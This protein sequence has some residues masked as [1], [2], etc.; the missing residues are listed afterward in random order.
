MTRIHYSILGIVLLL[1]LGNSGLSQAGTNEQSLKIDSAG[2]LI[3]AL[4]TLN[5]DHEGPYTAQ[6]IHLSGDIEITR[7]FILTAR[8]V[9]VPTVC[10]KRDDCRKAV[11]MIIP[12]NMTGVKCIKTE[13]VLG[14]EH[15]IQAD[16]SEKSTFRL[17]A[18]LIDTHPWTYN[19]I[20]VIEFV[21]ASADGCK[22]GE[23]Q[24]ARDKT[25]WKDFNSYCRYCLERPVETCACQ[26]EKGSLPD[27]TACNF[28]ISGDLICSGKCRDGQCAAIDER[29]R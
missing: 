26:N 10:S 13:E 19:F 12:K 14:T 16:L 22:P 5:W 15:C 7:A 21:Q 4:H 23:L 20:P 8:D 17:R 9:A 3:N 25:C 11:T 28:F 1:L 29:C 18:K 24:C 27:K 6:G 2:K